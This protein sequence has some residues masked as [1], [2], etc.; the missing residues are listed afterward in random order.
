M[1]IADAPRPPIGDVRGVHV[2]QAVVW[3]ARRGRGY[4]ER[5]ARVRFIANARRVCIELTDGSLI[6]ADVRNICRG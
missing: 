1:R 6:F 2:G 5:E 3:R 4:L